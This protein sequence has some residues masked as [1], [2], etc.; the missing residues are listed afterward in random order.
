MLL[1]HSFFLRAERLFSSP[2]LWP[3]AFAVL[4]ALAWG[5][6]LFSQYAWGWEPC[7]LCMA[8]R[9]ALTLAFFFF[10]AWAA[11]RRRF[12]RTSLL[13][14]GA[15]S[16]SSLAGAGVAARHLWIVHFPPPASCGADFAYLMDALPLSRW[17]PLLFSGEGECSEA[18]SQ[19]LFLL[20]LPAWSLIL[21]FA[22]LAGT[23]IHWAALRRASR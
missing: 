2:T 11:F 19:A 15:F 17:L 22:L 12:P 9:F 23:W 16:L 10:L 14:F 7:P 8:Q 5:G 1:T 21:F 6:A 13:F 4:F 3:A 18:G 20:S